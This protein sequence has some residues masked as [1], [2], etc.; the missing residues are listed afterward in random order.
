MIQSYQE[1][2]DT[3]AGAISKYL[4]D[5]AQQKIEFEVLDNG[6]CTMT[7]LINGNK[8]SFILAKFGNEFKVGFAF[9]EKDELQ[10]DWFDDAFNTEFD[11]QF[12]I[13]LITEQLLPDPIF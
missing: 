12:V 11:E 8:L 10:P 13:N 9:F 5:N 4:A 1:L 7:N 2:H 6:S 3:V